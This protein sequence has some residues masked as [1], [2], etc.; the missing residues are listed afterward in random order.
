MRRHCFRRTCLSVG[1]R[2]LCLLCSVGL[3]LLGPSRRVSV[4]STCLDSTCFGVRRF[5]RVE[6]E[7]VGRAADVLPALLSSQQPAGRDGDSE[8]VRQRAAGGGGGRHPGGVREDRE[9]VPGPHRPAAAP[10]GQPEVRGG[11]V[12]PDSRSVRGNTDHVIDICRGS[13]ILQDQ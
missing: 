12:D 11:P 5:K 9:P 7:H 4:T 8:D 3:S 10:A 2:A 1:P 13:I 6:I